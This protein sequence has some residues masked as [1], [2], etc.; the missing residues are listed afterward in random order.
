MLLCGILVETI[1]L[2]VIPA[3]VVMR[4]LSSVLCVY[5]VSEKP[6]HTVLEGFSLR[7]SECVCACA[8]AHAVKAV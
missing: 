3:Y 4:K 5:K 6:F 2:T 8:C 1:L 7:E